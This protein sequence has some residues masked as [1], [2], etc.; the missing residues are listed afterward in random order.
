MSNT[1]QSRI[2]LAQPRPDVR[3][4]LPN[5]A[6]LAGP[7]G[8]PIEAFVEQAIAQGII[9][10]QA[11]IMAAVCDG[12]L[13]ELA[14]ELTRDV[15]MRLVTLGETDGGRIYRRSLVLLMTAAAQELWSDVHISVDHAVPDGGFFCQPNNREPL[16]RAEVAALEQRMRAIVA[17]DAPITQRDIT[18]TQARAL[19]REQ[20]AM[21]KVRLFENRA[22]KIISL[23]TLRQ[24]ENYYYGYMV[25]STRYL[26]L[27]SL[28]PLD[29]GFILQYPVTQD[30][31]HLHPV[32]TYDKIKAIF[33]QTSQW[34][35]R[36]GIEDIGRLNERV[37]HN[38]IQEVIL[39]AEALHEQHVANI[40]TQ[41]SH[42]HRDGV[43]IVLIAG[44]SSSGKTTFAKRLAIQLLAHALSPFTIEMDN[45]FVDREQTPRDAHGEYDF[46]SLHALHRDLLNAHLLK[47]MQGQEVQLPV[48][49]F[50]L[51][52]REAGPLVQ[53]GPRQ[54]MILEG[55]H[56][57]NPDLVPDIPHES[58]FRIYVSA[59]TQLNIDSHNRVPT[60]D[61]RLIRRIVRDARTRGYSAT[62]TLD[63]WQSVRRGEKQNI[64]P[65]QENAHVM[66]NSALPYELA[67]LRPVVTPLLQ[68][69]E[70]GSDAHLEAKRLLSFLR[71]VQ[72]LS[73]TQTAYIPD[74]SIL[75]EFIGGSILAEYLP[76]GI[77]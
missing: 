52:K 55:I 56:G 68:Q 39:V 65:Y 54:I 37:R 13:R 25:P 71:W 14:H 41:I 77:P 48:F 15:Q 2:T 59:L 35:E 69:V 23:Y 75:R 49:N 40:A 22:D 18:I 5:G 60:T 20:G 50:I 28:I 7:R 38:I 58:I 61:V 76:G 10:P 3:V 1:A 31:T 32:R 43:R 53:L 73:D 47:L 9:G 64:F 63:R 16:N 67:A 21:D 44:P 8:T 34:L 27:F 6:T 11:P 72:P 24:H 46:E 36:L 62:E 51:G 30:P 12:H 19:F 66:F 42:A 70:F 4:T 17:A 26:Q 57:L 74:T 33:Q 29:D 45:Y